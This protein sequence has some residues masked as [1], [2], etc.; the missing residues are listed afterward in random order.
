MTFLKYFLCLVLLTTT[1]TAQAQIAQDTTQVKK[2]LNAW[3][4]LKYD[5][6]SMLGGAGHAITGP[7]RWDGDDFLTAGGLVLGTALVYLADQEARDYF[8]KQDKNAPQIL[9]EVGWYFGSPQNF[10]MVTGAFYGLGLVTKN[11]KIR[12]TAVLIITSSA[13]AGFI[14]SLAK[15]AVGRARPDDTTGPFEFDF[16]SS[17]AKY[18]SFPSGHTVLS[19]SMAHSIAKQFDNIWLK[20]GIYSLGSIAPVSRLWDDAHWLTD[21]LL[22]AALS[23]AVVDSVDNYLNSKDRYPNAKRPNRIT[24]RLQAGFGRIGLVGRF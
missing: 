4:L 18:H 6:G 16:F 8:V 3:G 22:G 24:W 11:Q 15:T 7:L 21:I 5:L 19:V 1:I 23:I 17:Q 13:T 14:Q 10:Y 2:E 9:K 20:I 12:K